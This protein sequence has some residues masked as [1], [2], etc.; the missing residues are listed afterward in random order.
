MQLP[1]APNMRFRLRKDDVAGVSNFRLEEIPADMAPLRHCTLTYA[2]NEK[3]RKWMPRDHWFDFIELLNPERAQDWIKAYSLLAS[4]LLWDQGIRVIDLQE[5][6]SRNL[7]TFGPEK[8]FF[9]EER[10]LVMDFCRLVIVV[11][12]KFR[13]RQVKYL[14]KPKKDLERA[15]CREMS[16]EQIQHMALE[17]FDPFFLRLMEVTLDRKGQPVGDGEPRPYE[18]IGALKHMKVAELCH[19]CLEVYKKLALGKKKIDHKHLP[20]KKK[21]QPPV[22]PKKALPDEGSL[23]SKEKKVRFLATPDEDLSDGEEAQSTNSKQNAAPKRSVSPARAPLSMER[24]A[25]KPYD[26]EDYLQFMWDIRAS[27][28]LI[29]KDL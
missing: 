25:L 3:T 29:V 15:D 13:E 10:R 16:T 20:L 1:L 23:A 9:E 27:M 22:P 26:E 2:Q 28:A 8:A 14:L 24:A 17:T 12:Q 11:F 21:M 7:Y 5:A 19:V 4:D 6:M 18:D